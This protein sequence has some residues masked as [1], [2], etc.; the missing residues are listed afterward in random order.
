MSIILPPEIKRKRKI[1]VSKD[2]IK[3]LIIAIV[4]ITLIILSYVIN[5][6]IPSLTKVYIPLSTKVLLNSVCS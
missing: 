2:I 3:F 6:F 1:R 5:I 4:G